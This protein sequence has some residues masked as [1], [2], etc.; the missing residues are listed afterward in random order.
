[1]GDLAGPARG[2]REAFSLR[3]RML[4]TCSWLD[5]PEGG[6]RLFLPLHIFCSKFVP[7]GRLWSPSSVAFFL[8]SPSCVTR[9]LPR[10]RRHPLRSVDV[11]SR[12]VRGRD[13]SEEPPTP[14]TCSV[15]FNARQS[16]SFQPCGPTGSC[17]ASV[18][19]RWS[20]FLALSCH[21]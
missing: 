20:L 12:I 19:L 2:L 11:S 13:F 14:R 9:L 17:R 18:W 3:A 7:R 10:R 16:R 1:M 21:Y 8:W 15:G 6:L 4:E 5:S